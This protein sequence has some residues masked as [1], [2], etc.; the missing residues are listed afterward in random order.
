MVEN[1]WGFGILDTVLVT[2]KALLSFSRPPFAAAI[3]K[4]N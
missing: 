4:K 1:F 3:G 2:F